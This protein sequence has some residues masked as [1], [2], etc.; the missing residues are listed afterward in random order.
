MNYRLADCCKLCDMSEA[1]MY[2]I[3]KNIES[4]M[5][6]KYIHREGVCDKFVSNEYF[7]I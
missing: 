2:L 7:E 5:Y 3:C 4:S 6:N 1:D